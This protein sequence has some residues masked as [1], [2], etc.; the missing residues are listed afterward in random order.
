MCHCKRDITCIMVKG[1]LPYHDKGTLPVSRCKGHYLY[2]GKWDRKQ[3]SVF[4]G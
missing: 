3:D 1:T 2:H 4:I